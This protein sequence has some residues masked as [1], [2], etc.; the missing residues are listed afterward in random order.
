MKAHFLFLILLLLNNTFLTAQS[1]SLDPTFGTSGIVIADVSNNFNDYN[2][3]AALLPDG[4]ILLSG[5]NNIASNIDFLL[6]RFHTDGSLDDSFG[7]GGVVTTDFGGQD[8]G[9]EIFVQPDGKIL[10]CGV[11]NINSERSIGLVRYLPDGALDSAFGTDGKVITA[12]DFNGVE[13]TNIAVQ[14]DGKIIIA[15]RVWDQL[16]ESDFAAFRYLSDGTLDTSFGVNGIVTTDIKEEDAAR[17]MAIQTDDKIL[18]AG[19]ASVSANGDF[20]LVR[21]NA[22][23]TID[24]NFGSGGM[25]LTDVGSSNQSEFINDML[26]LSDGK[27]LVGGN[28]FYSNINGFSD[29]GLV[30]YNI[31]GTLDNTF[32]TN[33]EVV[34]HIQ[35]ADE[36]QCLALQADGKIFVGGRFTDNNFDRTWMLTR[37]LADGG[38]D[39]NFGNNG[40]VSTSFGGGTQNLVQDMLVQPD[41]KVVMTGILGS[42]PN[43][44]FGMARYIADFTLT[45]NIAQPSCPGVSDGMIT[46]E[47]SG[48]T[49]P[50][51]YS[52]NGVDF[53]D[54]NVFNDLAPGSYTITVEDANG[55]K[56]Y[57]TSLVIIE[58]PPTE[59]TA[60]VDGNMITVTVNG[61]GIYQ[62]S[63]D[64]G[65]TWQSSNV[66]TDVP[67]GTYNVLVEDDAG[68]M[69]PTLT[70]IVDA[71]SVN[72]A[73]ALAFQ[74]SPNPSN[75]FFILKMET[76]TLSAIQM[77]VTDLSGK[78]VYETKL[79]GNGKIEQQVDL[80][81]LAKGSYLLTLNDGQHWV[82][83]RL[84]ILRQ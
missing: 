42:N 57:Y 19:F 44:N 73:S 24:K 34:H 64:G 32:G 13:L 30:R 38:I 60:E 16:T 52:I 58:I 65:Q 8:R 25:V 77:V 17:C 22:D 4:K 81:F 55:I 41:G 14:S 26:L 37:F 69:L 50:Y 18:L 71:V 76:P 56:G 54:S 35:P 47:V 75:G 12:I 6:A 48:G 10:M 70:V 11:V 36:V 46:M 78:V 61:T 74:I 29:I 68:C 1:G 5:F 45:A 82:G 62:Y 27:I 39:T 79:A 15:G 9:G 84:L 2:Y 80:R 51:Q 66:F 43:Y 23:G 33:G 20:A 49:P 63:I 53:Q 72:E 21:Y 28:A 40:Y 7:I 83:K 31:D 67:D 3:G 59:F